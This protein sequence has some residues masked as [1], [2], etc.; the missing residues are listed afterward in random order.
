MKALATIALTALLAAQPAHA[1]GMTY[2]FGAKGT[3]AD[4]FKALKGEGDLDIEFQMSWML[5]FISGTGNGGY[6]MAT[7]DFKFIR[8]SVTQFCIENPTERIVTAGQFV[9]YM[10]HQKAASDAQPRLKGK[11]KPP[12]VDY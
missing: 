2:G 12:G 4:W 3:C 9:A 1:G 10:L 7:S 11:V 5:G 6:E 8:S